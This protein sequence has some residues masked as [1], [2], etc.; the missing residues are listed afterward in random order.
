M[1][2]FL[3]TGVLLD[4]IKNRDREVSNMVYD[5][6]QSEK[7]SIS[8]SIFNIIELLDKLQ[9]IRHMGKLVTENKHSFDEI[10]KDRHIKKL[11]E[12]ERQEI[13]QELNNFQKESKI[14]VYQMDKKIGYDEVIRLLSK[15]D[16]KSQDAL[17]LGSYSTSESNLFL[18][19]DEKM[20]KNAKKELQGIFHAKKNI[21]EVKKLIK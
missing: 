2:I 20:A 9:E 10:S 13:L 8:T 4:Y 15:I 11:S 19:K 16:L 14:I 5:M 21:N 3:D 12:T 17:I 7:I 1:I 18:T 6:I